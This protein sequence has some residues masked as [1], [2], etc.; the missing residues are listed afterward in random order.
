MQGLLTIARYIDGLNRWVGRLVYWLGLLMILIGVYNATVRY[1][2]A[3]IGENLA[4]N[5]YLE[6]QWYLFGILFLLGASYTLSSN[7]HVRVDVLYGQLGERGRAIV[8]LAGTLLFLLPFCVLLTYLS[9]K[10]VSFSWQTLE[11]SGN[12]GG[13]PRYPIK[14]VVPVA[15]VLLGLQG[16]SQAIKAAAVLTGDRERLQD[17]TP[18][19][20]DERVR[21]L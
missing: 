14:T 15:F 18:A 13:L 1:L 10:W 3:Y 16:V 2:G 20:D 4:S 8:D 17:D 7:G 9:I 12:P 11:M 19:E 6:A 5:A 21:N